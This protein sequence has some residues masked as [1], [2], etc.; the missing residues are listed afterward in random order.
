MKAVADHRLRRAIHG[1]GVDHAAARLEEGG[2]HAGA[3]VP[4]HRI[5]ADVE[6]NPGPNPY[7]RHGLAG[8]GYE[9]AGGRSLLGMQRDWQER[10]SGRRQG[11]PHERSAYHPHPMLH[12]RGEEIPAQN[13]QGEE[14]TPADFRG[15]K[16][17]AG[18]SVALSGGHI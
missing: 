16:N 11:G 1:G 2:H 12:H 4:E 14:E 15:T 10:R 9:T 8:R 7:D 3:F 18:H 5:A 17:R 13:A 6:G